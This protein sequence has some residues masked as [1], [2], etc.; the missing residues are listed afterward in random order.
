MNPSAP[1]IP[2]IQPFDLFSAYD[3][4]FGNSSLSGFG[5]QASTQFIQFVAT[6]LT[7]AETSSLA[8]RSAE[9]YL[10]NLLALP[11]YYYHANN[12]SPTISPSPDK[13]LPGLPQEL[14]VRASLATA[15]HKLIV[16]K[17]TVWVYIIG[18]AL[19]ILA[20]MTIL[21]LGSM[22]Q[23]AGNI[24]DTTPW[25]ALDFAVHCCGVAQGGRE[26]TI[27]E[28]LREFRGLTGS[29]ALKERMGE[30][31][32]FVM[33]TTTMVTGASSAPRS[34]HKNRE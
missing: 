4:S 22:R 19:A 31:K 14:Y 25:S 28:R 8:F 16:G 23:T 18:G 33:S 20:C 26:Q 21:V 2:K 32:V 12:L 30:T 24:P 34:P 7:F 5:G 27:G 10:R 11:L 17:T 15:W 1:L 6:T 13:P 3:L 9:L 29:S